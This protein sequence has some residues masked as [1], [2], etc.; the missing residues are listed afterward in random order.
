MALFPW[1]PLSSPARWRAVSAPAEL[2]KCLCKGGDG[3]RQLIVPRCLAAHRLQ[4]VSRVQQPRTP[5]AAVQQQDLVTHG[6]CGWRLAGPRGKRPGA[7]DSSNKPAFVTESE[8]SA[9]LGMTANAW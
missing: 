6:G 9:G 2:V 1:A 3:V 5:A 4:L 8:T 7:A